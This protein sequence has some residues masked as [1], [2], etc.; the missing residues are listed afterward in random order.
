MPLHPDTEVILTIEK[1]VTG[2]RMLARHEGQIVFVAGAI[3]GERV[4][5]RVRQVE[6]QLAFADTVDVLEPSPDRRP[7]THRPGMRRFAVRPCG[8]PAAARPEVGAGR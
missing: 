1:P 5:A 4:R 8:L 2:G 7:T 6:K 3:P